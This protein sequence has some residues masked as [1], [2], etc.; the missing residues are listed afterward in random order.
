MKLLHTIRRMRRAPDTL[1]E[2][3]IHRDALL[4]NYNLFKTTYQI[5]VAPVLKG[6]AYGHGLIEVA[7]VLTPVSPIFVV[8]SLYEA[9][10]VR[11]SGIR[12]PLLVVGYAR[13]DMIMHTRLRDVS[14]TITSLEGLKAFAVHDITA[15]VHIKLDTGMRRQG[16]VASESDEALRIIQNS[17]LQVEGICSHFADADGPG[18]DGTRS[19]IT[20]WNE[21]ARTW[22]ATLP[23]IRYWHIAATAGAAYSSEIEANLIRVGSGVY[24]F[25]RHRSQTF[26]L[27]PALSMHSIITG[28]K[29]LA[30]GERVGYNGIFT[31]EKPLRIAT[32][33][34]GYY[35]GVDRRLSNTG[36]MLVGG[37]RCP[38]V[39]RVSMNITT[40]DV[41]ACADVRLGVSVVV[42]SRVLDDSNTLI[43]SADLCSTTPLEL[44]VHI[45][46]HLRRVV[47]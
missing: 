46:Q 12:T 16:I 24:G 21:L 27:K 43:K 38:I 40:I 44:L 14:F 19:Q 35:E 33:P 26:G 32:V 15:P 23:G 2:V 29:D 37:A 5:P 47:V 28:V 1:I 7:E 31:A 39:G 11:R 3:R 4:H 17:R 34:V 20:L 42:F 6:N 9:Q 18:E 45:P 13:P 36:S 10:L 41:S 8:D 30:V 22:R 25:P